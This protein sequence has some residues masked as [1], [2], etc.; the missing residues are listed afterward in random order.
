MSGE[1]VSDPLLEEQNVVEREVRCEAL[2]RELFVLGKFVTHGEHHD[3]F[4]CEAWY[5][6]MSCETLQDTAKWARECQRPESTKGRS[7]PR[8]RREAGK[9]PEEA[10]PE[11]ERE[12]PGDVMPKS[13]TTEP[14]RRTHPPAAGLP[15]SAASYDVGYVGYLPTT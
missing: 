6:P 2:L 12:C 3:G 1:C 10:R 8:G 4:A 7:V 15:L 9:C 5:T 14:W 11:P 13:V